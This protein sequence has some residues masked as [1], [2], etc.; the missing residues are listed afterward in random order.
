MSDSSSA[1]CKNRP[2]H[3]FFHRLASAFELGSEF[4]RLKRLRLLVFP[5]LGGERGAE[6]IA[7][8]SDVRQFSLER[9]FVHRLQRVG[10]VFGTFVYP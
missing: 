3:R 5:V 4:K 10:G 1:L 9:R 8:A 6:G 7:E 2:T